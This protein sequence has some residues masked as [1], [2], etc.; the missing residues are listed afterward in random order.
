MRFRLTTVQRRVPFVNHQF[1]HGYRHTMT[2]KLGHFSNTFMYGSQTLFEV[3][4]YLVLR[5]CHFV[6]D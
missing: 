6:S 1:G 2:E 4:K 5:K 3:E